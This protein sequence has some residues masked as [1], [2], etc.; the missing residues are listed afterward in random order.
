MTAQEARAITEGALENRYDSVMFSILAEARSGSY[1]AF[2]QKN[3]DDE[4]LAIQLKNLGYTI[5][6]LHNSM[7]VS[8]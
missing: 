6:F 1:R 2:F 5:E 4:E 3:R 7:I 8:W